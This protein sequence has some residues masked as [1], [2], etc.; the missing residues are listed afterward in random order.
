MTFWS[1][2]ESIPEVAELG[3]FALVLLKVVVNQAGVEQIFSDLKVKAA[4]RRARLGL[5]KLAKMTKVR[6]ML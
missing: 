3:G 6:L 5:V 4:H 2:F 1:A